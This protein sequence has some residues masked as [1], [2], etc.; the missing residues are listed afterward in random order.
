[1]QKAAPYLRLDG[2]PYPAVVDGR[3]LWILDGY[4][5][6]D[7]YPYSQRSTLRELTQDTTVTTSESVAAQPKDQVNYI[8]NSV[9]ATVDAYD[10]T[11]T[12]YAWDEKDPVR[13]VLTGL[14]RSC[15]CACDRPPAL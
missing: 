11:V 5:T 7:G 2:D 8:R 3:I 9:R 14:T 13:S 12:L 15:R 1:V 4:T 6:G 10:G